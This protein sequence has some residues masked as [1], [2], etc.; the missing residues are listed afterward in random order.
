MIALIDADI[1]AYR[2]AASAESDPLD[3][4]IYRTDKLMRD[5]LQETSADSYRSFLSGK[6]NFRYDVYPEYKANRTSPDPKWREDCKEF[7]RLEWNSESQEHYEADDLLAIHQTDETVICS[8]DKDLKM[9]AGNHY[10]WEI[11]TVKWTKPAEW[12]T[13]SLE[14]G[15][16]TFYTQMLVGDR[17][18]NIIGID[19]LGPVK[20][21]KLLSCCE[22]EQEMFDAVYERYD[23]PERFLING[24]C[25]WMCQHEGVTWAHHLKVNNLILPDQLKPVLEAK[26]ECM[27]Y[28]METT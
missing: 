15:I 18:D 19:G 16:R 3:I 12:K 22:N 4:A 13:V 2:C 6:R 9:V 20:S 11:G 7:L 27:K 25:L 5:I 8:L 10:S 17:T 14:D 24:I 26:L 28:F 23:N 21:T 1:V